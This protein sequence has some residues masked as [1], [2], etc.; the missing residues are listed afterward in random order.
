MPQARIIDRPLPQ[1]RGSSPAR[2]VQRN[3]RVNRAESP[4]SW[5]KARGGVSDRQF[6]AGEQLR[7]DFER[8]SLMPGTTM[9]WDVSPGRQP[10]RAVNPA[11][12]SDA[13]LA[14]RARF[15]AAVDSAGPGL[16]D[17]LWRVVCAGERLPT[18]EKELGWP[19]RSGRLVLCMALDRVADFY[20]LQ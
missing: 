5:L 19:S 3:V 13:H 16:A 7:V 2:H 11:A 14:A 8:A 10:G 4:L 20:R 17:V 18:A 15:H 1:D 12:A 6:A 9:R